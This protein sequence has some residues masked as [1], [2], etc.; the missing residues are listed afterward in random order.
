ML[1]AGAR[2][3]G[4]EDWEGLGGVNGGGATNWQESPTK[5]FSEMFSQIIP[6]NC[7]LPLLIVDLSNGNLV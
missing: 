4:K 7:L 1:M 5:N 6:C 3:S 2:G